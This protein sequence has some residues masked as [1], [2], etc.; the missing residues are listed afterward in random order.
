MD[1][2]HGATAAGAVVIAA[3]LYELTPFNRHRRPCCRDRI[4]PALSSGV[5]CVGCTLGLMLVMLA[6]GVMS[7]PWMTVIAIIISQPESS[8]REDGHRCRVEDR[9][10]G[11]RTLDRGRAVGGPGHHARHVSA[12]SAKRVRSSGDPRTNEFVSGVLGGA[13]AAYP[14]CRRQTQGDAQFR[15]PSN[16]IKETSMKGTSERLHGEH[17]PNESDAYRSAREELL[18][19]EVELRECTEEVARLRRGLPA[20]GEIPEDYVFSEWDKA[21]RQPRDV[22]LSEL[23]AAGKDSLFVYSFMFVADTAGNPLG[24]PCPNC[25]SI[26]DAVAGEARHITQRINLAV[27][28]K[29]PIEQFRQHAQRRGWGDI[30]LLSA[31]GSTYNRDYLAEDDD[32]G[33]WP[34]ATV[35]VRRGGKVRHFW[36]SELFYVSQEAAETRH[37]DFMWPLWNILDC[38]PEGRG[39]DWVPG[40]SY[41]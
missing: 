17:L 18:Q 8:A 12:L 41:E 22:H 7:V 28:A 24:N 32:G 16:A 31:A 27:S 9:S 26:I 5:Y 29:V 33:Q 38:T 19:A 6:V 36:S 37:V 2:P 25:T 1:R 20:G 39:S 14:T 23:F 13:V 34:M 11:A 4:S 40:L 30:R 35:F 3:G 15:S 21:A 10:R